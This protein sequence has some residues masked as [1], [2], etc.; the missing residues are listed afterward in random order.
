MT[1]EVWNFRFPVDQYLQ[2]FAAVNVGWLEWLVLKA[3]VTLKPKIHVQLWHY[4]HSYS[5]RKQ[6]VKPNRLLNPSNVIPTDSHDSGGKSFLLHFASLSF[7]NIYSDKISDKIIFLDSIWRWT[8]AL[9]LTFL[10]SE[11]N[12]T[13]AWYVGETQSDSWLHVAFINLT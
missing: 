1:C 7:R 12:I 11:L 10:L 4:L 6:S 9:L 13:V 3:S 5:V 8:S 2:A